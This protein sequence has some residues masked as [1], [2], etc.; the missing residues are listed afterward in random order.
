M[1]GSIRDG[2]HE[3]LTTTI[4]PLGQ[5]RVRLPIGGQPHRLRQAR[6]GEEPSRATVWWE[7]PTSSAASRYDPVR[8][9]ASRISM[10]SSRDSTCSSGSTVTGLSNRQVEPEEHPIPPTQGRQQTSTRA[11]PA[12]A[13]G[14]NPWPPAGTYMA[15]EQNLMAADSKAQSRR[16]TP[17]EKLLA[18]AQHHFDPATDWEPFREYLW[19]GRHRV[20]AQHPWGAQLGSTG[21]RPT[22]RGRRRLE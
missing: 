12:A 1:S 17:R 22:D 8:S 13:T 9:N 20:T 6:P 4:R 14:Q 18:T 2:T 21:S 3:R 5:T 11:E 7:H 10:I 15:A 16:Y 19:L